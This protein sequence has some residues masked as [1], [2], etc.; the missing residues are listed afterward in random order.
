[1]SSHQISKFN[2]TIKLFLDKNKEQHTKA[3]ELQVYQWTD[4]I[5]FMHFAGNGRILSL[6]LRCKNPR[7]G[8]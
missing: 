7:L 6:P 4:I 1:M 3:K 2:T 5:L 8:L